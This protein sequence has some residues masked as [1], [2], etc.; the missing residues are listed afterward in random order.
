MI[1]PLE[2][3]VIIEQQN[4]E[5]ITASGL[6]IPDVAQHK[7][8]RGFIVAAGPGKPGEPI[9]VKEGDEVLFTEYAGA[10]IEMDGKPYLFMRESDVL[11]IIR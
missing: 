10:Q 11:G 2:D 6:I 4:A 5:S 3:R 9:T 7:P 8:L 1:Q